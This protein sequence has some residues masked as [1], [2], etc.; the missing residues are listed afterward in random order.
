[1]ATLRPMD[2]KPSAR[3]QAAAL[4]AA[5][6]SQTAR[7]GGAPLPAPGGAYARFR[8]MSLD[9]VAQTLGKAG[10]GRLDPELELARVDA[11][12]Q[13]S[14]RH[15]SK[16]VALLSTEER[17][18]YRE[19]LDL[20]RQRRTEE[21]VDCRYCAISHLLRDPDGKPT[22][23]VA[24]N[25]GARIETGFDPATNVS[26]GSV[27]DYQM[28]VRGEA[29][30]RKV[31]EMAHPLRWVQAAPSLFERADPAL[32]L[33]GG[34]WRAPELDDAARAQAIAAWGRDRGG[35]IYEKVGWAWNEYFDAK[36]ENVLRIDNLIAPDD[37]GTIAF[38][39]TLEKCL[40]TNFGVAWERGGLD[41]DNGQYRGRITPLDA[42]GE[43]D[44]P[45]NALDGY[46]LIASD[47]K[48]VAKERLMTP[49]A[50]TKVRLDRLLDLGKHLQE[51]WGGTTP[52]LVTLSASKSLRYTRLQNSPDELRAF[53]NWTSPSL[54]FVLL[55]RLV[56]Q[57]V[58]LLPDEL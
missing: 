34:R 52:V 45:A 35:F 7:A 54:L 44:I 40:L 1:M 4:G 21:A 8:P 10:P 58:H 3:A 55:N 37:H 14:G 29:L 9:R 48:S 16:A 28:F 30:A 6:A 46:P 47:A 20:H 27:T 56:C 5:L 23:V 33:G 36:A 39:Y 12:A 32:R 22:R 31:I 53:L 2:L 43:G 19:R 15:D 25:H 42:L 24:V 50:R 18:R 13:L 51:D 49:E 11:V 17:A 26:R 38:D 57:Y 41:V